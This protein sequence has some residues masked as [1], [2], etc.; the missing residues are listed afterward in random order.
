VPTQQIDQQLIKV[1]QISALRLFD[2]S[3]RLKPIALDAFQSATINAICFRT[4][5]AAW[6]CFGFGCTVPVWESD[7][8][9]ITNEVA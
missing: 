6:R 5:L 3:S 9:D 7:V 2:T 4:N 8:F 1:I